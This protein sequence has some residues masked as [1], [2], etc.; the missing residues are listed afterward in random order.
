M[1]K[2]CSVYRGRIVAPFMKTYLLSLIPKLQ[3]LSQKLDNTTLLTSQHWVVIDDEGGLKMGYIFRPNGDLLITQNGKVQKAKWE[4]LGNQSILVDKG[5]ESYLFKHGFFNEKLLALK[6]DS[7]NEYAL[8]VSEKEYERGFKTSKDVQMLLASFVSN[9][10]GILGS[11]GQNRAYPSGVKE[12]DNSGLY[13]G[14]FVVILISAI[15][16]VSYLIT[17]SIKTPY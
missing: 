11:N 4:Y 16:L 6:V 12:K 17:A 10:I 8:M 14:L 1:C 13:I 2:N 9:P 5:E 3:E 7:T 15:G